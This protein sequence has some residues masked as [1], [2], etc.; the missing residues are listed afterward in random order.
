[1]YLATD[2][3]TVPCECGGRIKGYSLG[4]FADVVT[5]FCYECHHETQFPLPAGAVIETVGDIKRAE[6]AAQPKGA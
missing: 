4:T 3:A 2:N 6:V 5:V 1:M